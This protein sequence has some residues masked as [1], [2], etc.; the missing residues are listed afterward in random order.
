MRQKGEI[1]STVYVQ[2]LL[3]HI[4]KVFCVLTAV[5]S[6]RVIGESD[7][8]QEFLSESDEVKLKNLLLSVCVIIC[9]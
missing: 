1:L 4:L 8:M 6:V 9:L 5:C 3:I 7:V 2:A